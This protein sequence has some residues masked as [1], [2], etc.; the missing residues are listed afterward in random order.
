MFVSL[1]NSCALKRAAHGKISISI[2]DMVVLQQAHIETHYIYAIAMRVLLFYLVLTCLCSFE[3]TIDTLVV[4][5]RES[6][7]NYCIANCPIWYAFTEQFS[8][9]Y[10]ILFLSYSLNKLSSLLIN[11]PKRH[12]ILCI[13]I[14]LVPCIIKLSNNSTHTSFGTQFKFHHFIWLKNVCIATYSNVAVDIII[15]N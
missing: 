3:N 15:L 10:A 14:S 12:F 9:K 7:L 1:C 4:M 2:S 11:V 13:R 5:Y 6:N 8:G